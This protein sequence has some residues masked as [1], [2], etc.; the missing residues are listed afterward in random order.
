[1]KKTFDQTKKETAKIS[2]SAFGIRSIAILMFFVMLFT[3]IGSGSV[4]SALAVTKSDDAA[5]N[6][7]AVE[8]VD[9]A[10]VEPADDIADE[11]ATEEIPAYEYDTEEALLG[12]KSDSDLAAT[13]ANAELAATGDRYSYVNLYFGTSDNPSWKT[14]ANPSG[15]AYTFTQECTANTTYTFYYQLSESGS[16]TKYMGV[17]QTIPLSTQYTMGKYSSIGENKCHFRPSETA[18]YT[19]TAT[20]GENDGKITITGGSG[21]ATVDTWT[22]AGSKNGDDSN[23]A[24]FGTAWSASTAS[25]DMTE[26]DENIYVK[27]YPNV[28]FTDNIAFK[29]VQNHNWST[30]YPSSNFV[31]TYSSDSSTSRTVSASGNS[32]YWKSGDTITFTFNSS[33]KA[34]TV[35]SVTPE[36][37]HDVTFST[38]PNQGGVISLSGSYAVGEVTAQTVTAS[39]NSAYTFSGWTIGSGITVTSGTATGASPT[40]TI[41]IKTKASG[42]YTVQ[43]NFTKKP[44]YPITVMTNSTSLGTAASSVAYG[45][46]GQTIT[47]TATEDAGTFGTWSVVSGG[48]N[49]SGNTKTAT[50][51]MPA[52]AVSIR[53]N[54]NLYTGNN[55]SKYYYDGWKNSSA[56]SPGS[57]WNNVRMTEGMYNGQKYSYFHATTARPS[58]SDYNKFSI[59]YRESGDRYVYFWDNRNGDSAWANNPVAVFEDATGGQIGGGVSCEYVQGQDNNSHLWKFKIPQSS[60]TDFNRVARVYFTNGKS[61]S[62][63]QRTEGKYI[64]ES[65][66]CFSRGGKSANN[67]TWYILQYDSTPRDDSN[68]TTLYYWG[69][70]NGAGTTYQ[71]AT[72]FGSDL[73]LLYADIGNYKNDISMVHPENAPTDYYIIVYYPNTNYGTINGVTAN[74]TNSYPIVVASTTLP[75]T[76]DPNAVTVY[77]KDGTLRG[78]DGTNE[79]ATFAKYADTKIY[80]AGGNPVGT[81]LSK[82]GD[83][84]SYETYGAVKGETIT[85]ETTISSTTTTGYDSKK[86]NELYY[87]K[88]FCI[89]GE[90]PD[91]TINNSGL[92]AGTA[93]DGGTKYTLTYTIPENLDGNKLEITPIYYT[94]DPNVTTVTFQVD[95]FPVGEHNWGNTLYV[96]PFYGKLSG[97]NN[98]MG[99]YPGQPM[100][101]YGGQYYIQVPT[102]SYSPFT[103]DTRDNSRL[104]GADDAAKAANRKT[105]SVSGMTLHNGFYDLLHRE[106]WGLDHGDQKNDQTQTYDY[107][108]F[109]K[110]YNE[111]GSDNIIFQYKYETTTDNK[112]VL[113][114]FTPSDATH[115]ADEFDNGFEYLVD[116]KGRKVNLFGTVL[117]ESK[118]SNNPIYVVSEA[119]GESS[120]TGNIAGQFATQWHIFVPSSINGG[121]PTY[122]K[123][124]VSGGKDS[125]PPSVLLLE[126]ENSFDNT[127]YP[128]ALDGH[129]IT[130]WK[131]YYTNLK[132]DY[133]DNPVLITYEKAKNDVTSD[134]ATRNDGRW[135]FSATGEPISSNIR[136]D[137]SQDNGANYYP[138]GDSHLK[139]DPEDAGSA[140]SY[141][142]PDVS[143]YFTNMGVNG[144]Q[145]YSTTLDSDKT[146]DFTALSNNANYKFMGW[147]FDNGKKISG[148]AS[149]T[150]LRNNSYTF[151]ARFM[152]VSV[153]TLLLSHVNGKGNVGGTDYQ[154][155][156]NVSIAVTVTD[157]EGITVFSDTK[158]GESITIP[159]DY[160]GSAKNYDVSVTLTA[161]PANNNAPGTTV[162]TKPSGE[163]DT[164]FNY[165]TAATGADGKTKTYTF[166]FNVMND[167]Y[168]GN[169]PK[170][171]E[172]VYTSYFIPY[173]FTYNIN[174]EYYDRFDTVENDAHTGTKKIYNRRGTLT[175]DE[176]DA[177]VYKAPGYNSQGQL[178]TQRFLSGEF[179]QKLAPVVSNF[180]EDITWDFSTGLSFGGENSGAN[181][182]Y[183]TTGHYEAVNNKDLK[184]NVTFVLPYVHDNGIATLTDGVGTEAT[185]TNYALIKE[186]EQTDNRVNFGEIPVLTGGRSNGIYT[187]AEKEHWIAA[188]ATIKDASDPS[189]IKNFNYWSIAS[190]SAPTVEVARCYFAG[191]N[192]VAYDNYI[193]TAVYDENPIDIS[194]EQAQ[195]YITFLE[196]TRNQWNTDGNTTANTKDKAL[197]ADVLFNDFVLNYSYKAQDLYLQNDG[198]GDI[199]NLGVV[200]QRMDQLERSSDGSFNTDLSNYVVDPTTAETDAIKAMINNPTGNNKIP[201]TTV[202][203]IAKNTLDNKNRIEIFEAIY[204]AAGWDKDTQKFKT[205][206]AYKKYLYRAFSYMIDSSGNIVLSQKPAYFIMYDVATA[207]NDN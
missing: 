74:N 149:A 34:I 176:A 67:N 198:E 145:T 187:E 137:I 178:E 87:V 33:T 206:Y 164:F 177:Y 154:G 131:T 97:A 175:A 144:Q 150:T 11:P 45:Y 190:T 172:L 64:W 31:I 14:G 197:A 148:S 161:T 10:S 114:S 48:A 146:Y 152:Y 4:L 28:T 21:G 115:F 44:T 20:F 82:N 78:V 106:I 47:L 159:D 76:P 22:V 50:F 98:A 81:Q 9:E 155:K 179:I 70:P 181:Y 94:A 129:S 29:I 2:A 125:I 86:F 119:G 184:R 165:G 110:I 191:F 109:Y 75:M 55:T 84:Y 91:G 200:V 142:V 26:T 83:A 128:S 147:Y 108:D 101:Y 163:D 162:L 151:V 202:Q 167:L 19:F 107:D 25:N 205:N 166:G 199:T 5:D 90:V 170:T 71:Q 196:T 58:D 3:A 103:Y 134:K 66:G 203:A 23:A 40:T 36:T 207:T 193:I 7:A 32:M 73:K 132:K 27:S 12:R 52:K 57:G 13:G 61:G 127:T 24:F 188:P 79:Y 185:A 133:K 51:T 53:A 46:A 89:N 201:G 140:S 104:D 158:S 38:N 183:S 135:L 194:S 17:N 171:K 41:G 18:T 113:S 121:N 122:S 72:R 99:A 95:N 37:T 116:Y 168:D 105:V 92:S 136:I 111:K 173:T 77:A 186:S 80:D 8:T 130:D 100:V 93:V 174:F 192:F 169:S 35:T 117:L 204:S 88:G 1:M 6:A 143:A 139:E 153:S 102:K 141:T 124:T 126:D 43:A 85:I 96:Y 182:E 63:W 180:G 54:F 123:F 138:N 16:G 60:T 49:V 160:I 65:K 42:D 156:G 62:D 189:K 39:A 30:A 120:S 157:E 118:L 15:D 59:S 112:S 68:G 56:T 195:T 69:T